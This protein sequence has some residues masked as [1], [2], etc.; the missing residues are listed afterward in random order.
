MDVTPTP[1]NKSRKLDQRGFGVL[2]TLINV[3]FGI[4]LT[5]IGLRM[6]FLLFNANPANQFV[7]WVYEISQPLVAPFAGIFTDISLLNG[8]LEMATIV[9]LIV[10]GLLAAILTRLF[11]SSYRSHPV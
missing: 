7:A 6:V 10:Y 1:A 8:R 4:I 11:A 2:A 9:A 5:L 3:V